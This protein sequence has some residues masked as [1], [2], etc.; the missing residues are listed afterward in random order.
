MKSFIYSTI[1][2][3]SS[4]N[5]SEAKTN[6]LLEQDIIDSVNNCAEVLCKRRIDISSLKYI[7]HSQVTKV[8]QAIRNGF[9]SVNYLDC[10]AENNFIWSSMI[11]ILNDVDELIPKKLE[12]AL[13]DDNISLLPL[14][15][16]RLI[17]V[18]IIMI[19]SFA[20]TNIIVGMEIFEALCP[21]LNRNFSFDD[22]NLQNM[23]LLL[24]QIKLLLSCD[25]LNRFCTKISFPVDKS[26]NFIWQQ[27]STKSPPSALNNSDKSFLNFNDC[28]ASSITELKDFTEAED[29][30]KAAINLGNGKV[31][32]AVGRK[33]VKIGYE[34]LKFCVLDRELNG[35]ETE[36]KSPVVLSDESLIENIRLSSNVSIYF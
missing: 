30:T 24:R 11:N 25:V 14:Y 2:K 36:S 34:S 23:V 15:H 5:S 6:L 16:Q 32:D 22:E 3:F 9:G 33:M 1:G 12:S 10:I 13:N 8:T 4:K 31:R 19:E 35:E 18:L 26:S 17:G 7:Q 21:I 29:S 27:L 28:N 20:D